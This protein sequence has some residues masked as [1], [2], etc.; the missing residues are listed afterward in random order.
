MKTSYSEKNRQEQS[1]R[2]RVLDVRLH[3]EVIVNNPCNCAEINQSMDPLPTRPPETSNP[4]SG[5]SEGQRN[6]QKKSGHPRQNKRTF[7][8]VLQDLAPHEELVQPDVGHEVDESLKEGKQA[9]HSAKSNQAADTGNSPNRRDRESDHQES[10]R[11]DSSEL[12][13]VFNG[14]RAES[15]I[16]ALI[17]KPD[18]SANP[19]Q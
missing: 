7:V 1:V 10:Q 9:D 18:R 5:G 16:Q 2:H 6:H 11:P 19:S 15:A 14:V 8:D 17:G 13:Y 4:F 3:K 12:R